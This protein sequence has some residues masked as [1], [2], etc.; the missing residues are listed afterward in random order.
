VVEIASLND[1]LFTILIEHSRAYPE[2][3]AL[4]TQ[5]GR[6]AADFTE[7]RMRHLAFNDFGI[8]DTNDDPAFKALFLNWLT[9]FQHH[10]PEAQWS[11]LK[12]S[13]T[14]FQKS[15]WR[16]LLEVPFGQQVRYCDI[17]LQI[18]KL[19]A[20]RAVGSAIAANPIALLIPCHR[21]VPSSGGN[22]KYR[23]GSE[24]KRVL[25]DAERGHGCDLL[26]LFK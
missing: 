17:A 4:Q 18:G 22:G 15:V 12:P 23:W 5:C 13:G 24:R 16:A 11:Y 19:R 21:V 3:T 6:I 14:E 7:D 26:Q 20:A 10:C 1:N 8:S 25:L 9:C 2:N